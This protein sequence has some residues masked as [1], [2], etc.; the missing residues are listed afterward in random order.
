ML[1]HQSNYI[2]FANKSAFPLVGAFF[3]SKNQSVDLFDR[4]N[5]IA[6]NVFWGGTRNAPKNLVETLK[7]TSLC[8]SRPWRTLQHT[9]SS[10]LL[11]V[12]DVMSCRRLVTV[13]VCDAAF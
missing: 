3:V 13:G 1:D 11:S 10:S 6:M 5:Y 9:L 8:F 12:S 4:F 7:M 2:A